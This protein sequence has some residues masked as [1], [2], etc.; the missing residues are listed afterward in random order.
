MKFALG[1]LVFVRHC[2][3]VLF[4]GTCVFRLGEIK[5]RFYMDITEA[6]NTAQSTLSPPTTPTLGISGPDTVL[7]VEFHSHRAF[8]CWRW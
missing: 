7:I 6:M 2:R 5:T 3:R 8:A 4:D 1:L